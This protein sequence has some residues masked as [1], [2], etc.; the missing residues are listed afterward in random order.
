MLDKMKNIHSYI[1]DMGAG[2]CFKNYEDA[3]DALIKRNFP[4][5]SQ[6]DQTR[7]HFLPETFLPKVPRA[8][9]LQRSTRRK[10]EV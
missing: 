5:I 2:Q 3:E 4:D 6:N 1:F 8:V 9:I 7:A 10:R